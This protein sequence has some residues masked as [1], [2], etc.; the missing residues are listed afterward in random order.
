M[1]QNT[2]DQYNLIFEDKV[3][4]WGKYGKSIIKVVDTNNPYLTAF[5]NSWNSVEQIVDS[6]LPDIHDA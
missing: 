3:C 2:A 6:L 4:N 1:N 5:L